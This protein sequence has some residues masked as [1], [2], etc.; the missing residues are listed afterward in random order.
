MKRLD[1]NKMFTPVR[2][3]AESYRDALLRC[4]NPHPDQVKKK[5]TK[6]RKLSEPPETCKQV[7]DDLTTRKFTVCAEHTQELQDVTTWTHGKRDLNPAFLPF[8]MIYD[9]LTQRPDKVRKKEQDSTDYFNDTP[10][11]NFLCPK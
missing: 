1:P 8:V 2:K 10:R 9:E 5:K 4:E 7:K 3:D 6:R 11:I